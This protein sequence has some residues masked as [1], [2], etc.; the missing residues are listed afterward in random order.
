MLCC[1]WNDEEGYDTEAHRGTGGRYIVLDERKDN[2]RVLS[3]LGLG[4]NAASQGGVRGKIYFLLG[5]YN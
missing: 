3:E 1:L 4:S 2:D 5:R